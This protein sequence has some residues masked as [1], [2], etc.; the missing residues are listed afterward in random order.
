MWQFLY[1]LLTN[2][3][4][5]FKDIIEWTAN[6]HDKEFRMLEPESIAI[7]WGHHKNKPNMSYDKFSRSLRYYYDKGIL[8]KIPGERYVYRFLIDPEHMY[9]HIGTSD[10][11][12]KLKPMPQAARAAMSKYQ[13]DQGINMK[14]TPIVT[15]EPEVLEN[16]IV[17]EAS[18]FHGS[19]HSKGAPWTASHSNPLDIHP[20]AST[21]NLLDN[22]NSAD[23]LPIK[24]SKSLEYEDYQPDQLSFLTSSS[25]N[26]FS[27]N[28]LQANDSP[29]YNYS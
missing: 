25:Y 11:R 12:P 14:A 17:T 13:K 8:K 2:Q 26:S 29:Y 7:Y 15:G 22:A 27:S 1:A 20:S 4:K 10:C 28:F 3:E 5:K 21:G 19:N 16:K 6:V 18:S 24:R 9:Q 23:C